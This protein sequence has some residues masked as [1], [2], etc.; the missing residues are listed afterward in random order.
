MTSN[1]SSS[2]LGTNYSSFLC[3]S[4]ALFFHS[5]FSFLSG[6]ILWVEM[7]EQSG[8]G[9]E[10]HYAHL[11]GCLQRLKR[12]MDARPAQIWCLSSLNSVAPCSDI[13][14]TEQHLCFENNLSIF[15]CHVSMSHL[16]LS[17][18]EFSTSLSPRLKKRDGSTLKVVNDFTWAHGLTCRRSTSKWGKH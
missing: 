11:G 6:L 10:V 18:Y 12:I 9:S 7:N 14:F 8:D 5:S 2:L 13:L 15:C 16:Q 3:L 4:N 1:C 17:L